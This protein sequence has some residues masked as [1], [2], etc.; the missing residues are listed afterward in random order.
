M[1]QRAPPAL[2]QLTL[3]A[4]RSSLTNTFEIELETG[5]I[6]ERVAVVTAGGGYITGQNIRV[7]G[8]ITRSV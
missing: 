7:D 6:D 2:W 4:T 8:G 3:T 1:L 5:M